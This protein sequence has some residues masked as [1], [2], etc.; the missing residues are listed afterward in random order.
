M[1]HLEGERKDL[2]FSQSKTGL[3]GEAWQ[4]QPD[5]SFGNH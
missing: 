2:K 4:L 1:N 3:H 5:N